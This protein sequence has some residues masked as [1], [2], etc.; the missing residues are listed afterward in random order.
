MRTS[1]CDFPQ[2][3]GEIFFNYLESLLFTVIFLR[4]WCVPYDLSSLP[5]H[6]IRSHYH[7]GRNGK[8]GAS[9]GKL[10]TV[11]RKAQKNVRIWL[12]TALPSAYS[13]TYT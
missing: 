9:A 8:N 2:K 4:R 11:R 13:L 10:Q 7:S 6:A 12:S 3:L 1:L 5:C